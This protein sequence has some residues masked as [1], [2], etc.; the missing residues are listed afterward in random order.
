MGSDRE[1]Y[2]REVLAATKKGLAFVVLGAWFVGI[3]GTAASFSVAPAM[4]GV[5]A[6]LCPGGGRFVTHEGATTMLPDGQA[7][8]PVTLRCAH[9]DGK[10]SEPNLIGG[11]LAHLTAWLVLSATIIAALYWQPGRNKADMGR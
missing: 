1:C 5:E 7:V 8:A 6:V 10:E 11:A 9:P 3:V 4:L 2:P